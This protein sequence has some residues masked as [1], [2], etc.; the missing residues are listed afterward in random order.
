[1]Q[2]LYKLT[3]QEGFTRKG[4]SNQTEWKVGSIIKATGKRG[5]GLCSDEYLHAYEHPLI[6]QVMNRHHANINNPRMFMVKGE[7]DKR[8]GQLKC[9]CLELEVIEEVKPIPQLT[10]NQKIYFAILC[11]KTVYS[12]PAWNLWADNWLSKKDR[13]KEAA[14]VAYAAAYD[15]AYAVAYA[16]AYDAAYDAAYAAYDA[17]YAAAYDAAAAARAAAA[18]TD[19]YK[20][21]DQAVREEKD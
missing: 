20:L 21:L 1:M 2:I 4:Q 5:Q 14:Y 18:S 13:T 12:N 6:A 10:L 11:V 19:L 17:A 7:V 15:A 9:G 8:D 16:A 3:D